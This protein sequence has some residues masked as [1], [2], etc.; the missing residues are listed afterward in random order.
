MVKKVFLLL[1]IFFCSSKI[2]VNAQDADPNLG[3]IPAPVSVKKA[4]GEFILSQET[5]LL[6]DSL[7]NKSVLFLSDYLQ[8]KTMLHIQPK[9]NT[10]QSINNSIILTSTGT[11]NLPPEGYRLTIT[12]QNITIA[13]RGA[14]LFYGIQT[15]IQLMPAERSGIARLPCVH[16]EDYPRFGYRGLMLDVCRH[17]FSVEFVKN[18][19][20]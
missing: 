20:T 14:G 13:A 9:T 19:S 6:A 12:P 1:L 7:T 2:I 17:F 4:P 8:N 15:L 3:I 10:G 18:I 16:I 5:T 11:D